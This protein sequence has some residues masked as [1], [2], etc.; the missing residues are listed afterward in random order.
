MRR[1]AM[2][3]VCLGLGLVLP[4]CGREEAEQAGEAMEDAA[5]AAGKAAR[6]AAEEAGKAADAAA[7]EAAEAADAAMKKAEEAAE[8][9]GEKAN[10]MVGAATGSG[11]Q[12]CLDLVAAGKFSEAVPVCTQALAAD[13]TNQAVKDALDQAKAET[14]Q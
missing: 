9:A 11:S 13:P 14:G 4:T 7:Q 3:V 6:E 1:L 12:G 2:L 5:T 8:A 10:E